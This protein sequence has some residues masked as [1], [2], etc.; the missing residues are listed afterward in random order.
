MAKK[1]GAHV[2]MVNDSP[3]GV[4]LPNSGIDVNEKVK[5]LINEDFE[6]KK[7]NIMGKT[8]EDKWQSYN[9]TYFWHIDN[10]NLYK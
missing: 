6:L 2:I 4:V 3:V 9:N 7:N 8:F 5:Q 1:V 10:V